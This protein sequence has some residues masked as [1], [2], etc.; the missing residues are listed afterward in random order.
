[1]SSQG[2]IIWVSGPAVKADNMSGTRMYEVVNVGEDRLVG[3][4]IKLEGDTAFIQVYEST[5]NIRPG[6]PVERTGRPL[7]VALGPGV[8]GSIFDG[9]QRPL[10]RIAEMVGPFV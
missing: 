6:E 5:S 9:L 8:I 1:M 7:S 10:N 3:E 2:R 4:V